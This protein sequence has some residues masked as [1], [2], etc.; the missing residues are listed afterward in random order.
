MQTDLKPVTVY[1]IFCPKG[2]VFYP[3]INDDGT[4]NKPIK[5]IKV[6]CRIL[7][8]RNK[9]K[10]NILKRS[11]NLLNS[12]NK[13]DKEKHPYCKICKIYLYDQ[14]NYNKHFRRLHK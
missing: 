8:D 14:A 7:L 1:P 5:C 4:I 9:V 6:N 12:P 11:A 3:K 2:H 13:L 10:T